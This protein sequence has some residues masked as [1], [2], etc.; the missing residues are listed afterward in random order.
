MRKFSIRKTSLGVSALLFLILVSCNL[1]DGIMGGSDGFSADAQAATEIALVVEMTENALPQ[2]QPFLTQT[3]QAMLGP[4]ATATQP[5]TATMEA[6]QTPRPGETQTPVLAF[7]YTPTVIYTPTPSQTPVPTFTPTATKPFVTDDQKARI[8][9]A[10]VLVLEDVAGDPLLVPRIDTV[11]GNMGLT[12]ENV[13]NTHD[14]TGIFVELLNSD[15]TWDL[16]I[17]ATE[18]RTEARLDI[19]DALLEHVN[20]G[21]ALIIEAW[22]LDEISGG[23]I[24]PLLDTCGV[25]VLKDWYRV[26]EDEAYNFVVYDIADNNHRLFHQPRKVD[27]PLIPTFYWIGDMGDLM[28]ILPVSNSA[29]VG[30]LHVR[31]TAQFGLLTE[32]VE[33]RMI[34]QTFSTH[35]Y[36]K[37]DTLALWENYITNALL[38]HFAYVDLH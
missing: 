11:L 32:C 19:W 9:N 14:A 34:L 5:A 30:G 20:R 35:S 13:V 22:Y 28:E 29:L 15:Q 24:K 37:A 21:G 2:P 8:Q 33:G 12:G 1:L 6:T 25:Q 3:Q 36:K 38:S 17:V 10:R 26:E 31:N 23:S 16:I 27:M 4:S 18:Q 7:T